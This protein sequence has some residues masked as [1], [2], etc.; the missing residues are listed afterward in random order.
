MCCFWFQSA[1][2]LKV[3][4]DTGSISEKNSR[5]SHLSGSWQNR[6]VSSRD[7]SLLSEPCS[8][9]SVGGHNSSPRYIVFSCTA[10]DQGNIKT[11][12]W[13]RG[14]SLDTLVAIHCTHNVQEDEFV[15]I[16]CK[17][18]FP[19]WM[20]EQPVM[21]IWLDRPVVRA[22]SW[23]IHTVSNSMW[24]RILKGWFTRIVTKG[25]SSHAESLG[26]SSLG[27]LWDIRL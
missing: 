21:L 24:K 19:L 25:A 10:C 11:A 3:L 12:I 22:E 7:I 13:S 27:G 2:L 14:S 17:R 9:R 5:F 1:F 23:Y 26:F 15:C 18:F 20:S 4:A 16:N 8:A 6:S